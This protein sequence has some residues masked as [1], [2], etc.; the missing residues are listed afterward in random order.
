MNKQK[1]E[2]QLMIMQKLTSRPVII[3]FLFFFYSGGTDSSAQ[4]QDDILKSFEKIYPRKTVVFDSLESKRLEPITEAFI[5]DSYE[6][7]SLKRETEKLRLNIDLQKTSNVPYFYMSAGLNGYNSYDRI[8]NVLANV[9]VEWDNKNPIKTDYRLPNGGRG[10]MWI[11]RPKRW[12]EHNMELHAST[13]YKDVLQTYTAG[14]SYKFPFGLSI[15]AFNLSLHNRLMPKT[16]GFPFSTT[17]TNSFELPLFK[18]F[19]NDGS[20]SEFEKSMSQINIEIAG[21]NIKNIANEISY[22]TIQQYLKTYINWNMLQSVNG[23]LDLTEIQMKDYRI[24][25]DKN[26]ISVYDRLRIEREYAR[27]AA[28]KESS[29]FDYIFVTTKLNPIKLTQS[30]DVSLYI[31]YIDSLEAGAANLE[32]ILLNNYLADTEEN[33]VKINNEAIMADKYLQQSKINLKYSKNQSEPDISITGGLTAFQSDE[34]GYGDISRSLRE[35][36]NRSDGIAWNLGLTYRFNFASSPDKINYL[37]SVKDYQ[38]KLENLKETNEFIKQSIDDQILKIRAARIV[39]ENA[40][41]N[42]EYSKKVMQEGDELFSLQR[43]SRFDHCEY[44]KNVISEELNVL[45]A[46]DNYLDLL[47]QLSKFSGLA[48]KEVMDALEK[49]GS[50][51]MTKYQDN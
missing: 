16:Y 22:S 45:S 35:L 49:R 8:V 47:I 3:L 1:K 39:F 15:N 26:L 48:P 24:L 23:L 40:R 43:I 4:L 5:H 20:I 32:E 38:D 27:L 21:Q 42:L 36:F 25:V 14:L 9:P 33:L 41:K 34:L 2:L 46:F 31:P 11:P 28:Q 29:I 18:S 12:E 17:L 50:F 44:K 19:G 51:Q 37:I 10:I 7:S 6:I 13:A 30:Q